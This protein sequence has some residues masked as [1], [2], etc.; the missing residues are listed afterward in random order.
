MA[1]DRLAVDGR[2]ERAVEVAH[3]ESALDAVDHEMLARQAEGVAV[4]DQEVRWA[5]RHLLAV[6]KFT[7]D[8]EREFLDGDRPVTHPLAQHRRIRGKDD[9]RRPRGN[10]APRRGTRL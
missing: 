6:P 5:L 8:D 4:V 2:P 7:A 3:D 1:A 10:L 9:P